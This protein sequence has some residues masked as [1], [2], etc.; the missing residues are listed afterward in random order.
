MPVHVIHFRYLKIEVDIVDGCHPPPATI[1]LAVVYVRCG[2]A[3]AHCTTCMVRRTSM[4]VFIHFLSSTS[5]SAKQ[6]QSESGSGQSS[7]THSHTRIDLEVFGM[8]FD[9]WLAGRQAAALGVICCELCV[10]HIG[11]SLGSCVR[12]GGSE[13]ACV[14]YFS[15]NQAINHITSHS[16]TSFLSTNLYIIWHQQRNGINSVRSLVCADGVGRPS[17]TMSIEYSREEYSQVRSWSMFMFWSAHFY[18]AD[19]WTKWNWYMAGVLSICV[20][21]HK[22]LLLYV[23][24]H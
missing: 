5:L 4:R 21:Q 13:W 17:Y 11:T 8:S 2:R 15:F 14:V 9:C 10:R 18:Q 7:C 6:H 12:E 23:S 19:G 22:Q 1:T 16:F 24:I 3:C 20:W